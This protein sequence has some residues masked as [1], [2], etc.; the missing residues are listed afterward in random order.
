ML[1]VWW[2][3]NGIIHWEILPDSCT[4]TADRYCQ[5]LNRVAEKLKGKQDRIYYLHDNARPHVAK[6]TCEK[7]LELGWIT[8]PHPSYSPDLAPTD[9]HLFRSLF[10]HL[11]EK[12]FDDDGNNV[13]M[14]IANFFCQK[15]K[16]FYEREILTLPERCR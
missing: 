10:H 1:S 8:V 6:S 15:S 16:A 5:Q 11:R 3:V 2:G 7:L 14:D 12:G 4:I 9:Y 13:K